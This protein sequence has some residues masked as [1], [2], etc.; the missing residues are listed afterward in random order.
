MPDASIT[1][2]PRMARRLLELRSSKSELKKKEKDVNEEIKELEANLVDLMQD[3]E[4]DR[5][6]VDGYN[7]R[8]RITLYASVA[9]GDHAGAVRALQD[10]GLDEAIVLSPSRVSSLWRE[11]PDA[12]PPEVKEHFNTWEKVAVS[13]TKA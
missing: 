6:T 1:V 11:D 4:M 5:V 3:A 10:F 7:F 12:I 13:V 9:G 2:V 8:P